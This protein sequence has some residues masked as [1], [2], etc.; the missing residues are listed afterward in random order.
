MTMKTLVTGY[1]WF[2]FGGA[3]LI[4]LIM[5]VGVIQRAQTGMLDDPGLGWHLRN[6]D[7]MLDQKAWL[8]ADPFS[9]PRGGATWLTNQWLGDLVLWLGER[10]GGL[11]GI[12]AVTTLV[13]AGT[14]R[15]LYGML[16][17]DGLSAPAAF[18]WAI[19]A[20]LGTS[21][22]WVARP[23]VWT[24]PF[25]LITARVCEKLHREELT[26]RRACW[27]W[28][29][30]AIW[31]NMHGGFVA[32]LMV[33][34]ATWGIEA[35]S[36]IGGWELAQRAAAWRRLRPLSAIAAGAALATLCNPYGWRLYP[37]VFWLLG[38]AFFMQLHTEWHSPDFHAQGAGR[39]ELLIIL[40]PVLLGLS[41][42]RP[43][44]VLLGLSTL[45]L[46]YSLEGRR[47]VPLWVVVVT[48]LLARTS[49]EI[50]GLSRLAERLRVSQDVRAL[51][52]ARPRHA[53]WLAS[54]LVA[55]AL[56]GWARW[57]P[58]YAR[59]EPE[60]LPTAALDKLIALHGGRNIFH[61]YNWGGY[62]TWHGW[63][64]LRNWIDDRN[65]VQGR[66]HIEDYF[67]ILRT[68]P[69]WHDRLEQRNVELVCIPPNV[70]LAYRLAEAT[71]TWRELHRDHFA[72][73]F[74][75]YK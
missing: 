4:F 21:S 9:G 71:Q 67:A 22:S 72:V 37:W 42:H 20:A 75:R 73:L 38:D 28:P 43:N 23:N 60:N 15:L 59:H 66:E 45:W 53:G 47:Y 62:L 1:R 68:A 24:I 3:D 14:M 52:S 31:A 69:G 11:E 63:P 5:V 34:A 55:I 40:F 30:F 61:A 8:E 46:H 35:A 17:N 18:L 6:V 27:L 29:M 7:A 39:V 10:W 74:E 13:I 58:D 16:R 44:L 56:L 65:E 19:L 41:R 64:E 26:W 54:S 57:G 33:L 70:P 51:L 50:D 36:A 48:P 2:H 49:V 25:V 12:A 32:G